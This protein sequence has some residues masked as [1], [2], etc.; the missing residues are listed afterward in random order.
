MLYVGQQL[1]MPW[2]FVALATGFWVGWVSCGR[3]KTGD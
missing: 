3:A 2:L 1:L